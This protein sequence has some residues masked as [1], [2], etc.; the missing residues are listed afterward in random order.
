MKFAGHVR[1][2][3][4]PTADQQ[5]CAQHINPSH[6]VPIGYYQSTNQGRFG[7]PFQSDLSSR[8]LFPIRRLRVMSSPDMEAEGPETDSRES[9]NRRAVCTPSIKALYTVTGFD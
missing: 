1:H 6:N 8:S 3:R 2:P 7:Y 4:T 5:S 9:L